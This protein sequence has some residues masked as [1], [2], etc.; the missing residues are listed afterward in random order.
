MAF[1]LVRGKRPRNAR[2]RIT[3]EKDGGA[4]GALGRWDETAGAAASSAARAMRQ[5]GEATGRASAVIAGG[6]SGAA[7]AKAQGA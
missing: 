7:V 2:L 3:Q 1:F 4:R 6:D 5:A